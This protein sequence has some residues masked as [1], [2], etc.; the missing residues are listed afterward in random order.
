MNTNC[1]AKNNNKERNSEKPGMTHIYYCRAKKAKSGED[2]Q[3]DYNKVN[4]Q[5]N[6]T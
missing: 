1:N 4:E 3:N 6:R 5:A 2:I